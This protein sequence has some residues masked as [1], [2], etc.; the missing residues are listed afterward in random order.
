MRR[1]PITLAICAA[2]LFAQPK[3][4]PPAVPLVAHD[5]YFSVWSMADRLTG[6]TTKHWTGTEQQLS[7]LLRIDGA[8]F[9]FI[10]ALP[11][12]VPAMKQTG[13]ALTPTSTRYTFEAGG[14]RLVFTF[15]TPAL[16]A[17]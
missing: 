8:P 15:L 1:I 4:R 6:E 3:L 12:D 10:G 13:L 9:R 14:M 16:I 2:S 17:D 11:R 5:P 7:G